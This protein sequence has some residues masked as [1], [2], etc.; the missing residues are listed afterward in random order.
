MMK[1][2]HQINNFNKDTEMEIKQNQMEIL[3]LQ[4]TITKGS[5]SKFELAEE[6]ILKT[7]QQI[8]C[9]LMERE[10]KNEEDGPKRKEKHY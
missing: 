10:K 2:S 8:L 3:E 1:I 5:N 6:R 7:E 9:D 4:N